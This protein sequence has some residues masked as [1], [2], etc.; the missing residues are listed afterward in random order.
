[1]RIALLSY[2]IVFL[3]LFLA[4]LYSQFLLPRDRR[5]VFLKRKRIIMNKSKKIEGR[6]RDIYIKSKSIVGGES[7]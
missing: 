6:E 3:L 1:V 7:Q 5:Y 4:I 2:S